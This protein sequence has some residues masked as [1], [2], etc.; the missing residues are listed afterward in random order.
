[1]IRTFSAFFCFSLMMA[2][3]AVNITDTS[4]QGIEGNVVWLEG[5]LMPG[6]DQGEAYQQRRQGEPVERL[7]YIF[8]PAHREDASVQNGPLYE[9]VNANLMKV[10][11]TDAKGHFRVILP[12]GTYSVFTKED[13]GFF[14]SRFDERGRINPVEVKKGQFTTITIEVNYKAAY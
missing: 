4:P 7:V 8:E 10:V 2:S 9:E 14:A 5:N 6:P 11:P 1:M 13:D 12:P 3:C